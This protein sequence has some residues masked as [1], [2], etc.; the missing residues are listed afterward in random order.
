M[1]IKLCNVI[2]LIFMCGV[3]FFCL[4]YVSINRIPGGIT[5]DKAV[6]KDNDLHHIMH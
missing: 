5:N 6:S 4:G 1:K 2:F 3:S